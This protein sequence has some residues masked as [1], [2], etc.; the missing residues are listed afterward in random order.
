MSATIECRRC[1][2]QKD[3]SLFSVDRARSSGLHCYCKAC[4]LDIGRAYRAAKK[5]P[6]PPLM[7]ASNAEKQRLWK[8]NNPEAYAQ[9]RARRDPEKGK[10]AQRRWRQKNLDRE[11]RRAALWAK[12]N[13]AAAALLAASRR[14]A[15]RK[16]CPKWADKGR[17]LDVYRSAQAMTSETGIEHQVDHIVP[18]V[19]ARV[20]G[21]H[22]PANLRVMSASANAA[23]GNRHWPDMP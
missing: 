23:K 12:E 22:V 16:A 6:K 3:A 10:A 21:L 18:I 2:Q 13:P 20:C 9:S 17:M 8:A 4:H 7:Y 5:K 15:V 19:S 1:H 11:R 14:A